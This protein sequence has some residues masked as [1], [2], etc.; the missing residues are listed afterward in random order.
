MPI[1]S[2]AKNSRWRC[3]VSQP[4]ETLPVVRAGAAWRGADLARV[5]GLALVVRF[6]AGL[7]PAVL[8]GALRLARLDLH[9]H[10]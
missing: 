10:R 5:C 7:V 3:G 8:E 6:G 1:S 4:P 9:H 2:S